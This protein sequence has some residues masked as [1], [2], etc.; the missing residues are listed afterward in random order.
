MLE[1]YYDLAR[2]ADFGSLFGDLKIGQ[3]PTPLHNRYFAAIHADTDLELMREFYNGYR[4]TVQRSE[5]V[6]NPTLALYF[7]KHL[8]RHN[9]YPPRMLDDNLAMDR[10]QIQYV[11]RLPPGETLVNRALNDVEPLAIAQLVNRFG[12]QNMLTVLRDPDFLASLL[13]YCGVL[14]LT[15]RD[16][17]GKLKLTIPLT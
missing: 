11:A 15:G 8:V 9:A 12:V 2:A 1:N 17:L 10:N 5:Q 14:T 6:Y 16:A 3:N 7:L 4:F 13:Y